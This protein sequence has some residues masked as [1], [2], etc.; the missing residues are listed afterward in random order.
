M[1]LIAV[2]ID[3]LIGAFKLPTTSGSTHQTS[4]PP[5]ASQSLGIMSESRS[6]GRKTWKNPVPPV[7]DRRSWW[8]KRI[9]GCISVMYS[10]VL[11]AL[12]IYIYISRSYDHIIIGLHTCS[13]LFPTVLPTKGSWTLGKPLA[14]KQFFGLNYRDW[15]G[16]LSYQHWTSETGPPG[17]WCWR[18]PQQ[19][20]AGWPGRPS[21]PVVCYTRFTVQGLWLKV[22]NGIPKGM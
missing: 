3:S 17:R 10:Y 9:H 12:Y 19:M 15:L 7:S 16:W 6:C 21:F 4:Y 8:L 18:W 2:I 13:T 11:Y 20:F 22:T 1:N 5:H 14:K